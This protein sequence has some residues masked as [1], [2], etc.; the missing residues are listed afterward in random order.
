MS[1]S[2]VQELDFLLHA[3]L[4]GISITFLY[5]SF[6]VLR[7]VFKHG[8]TLIALEDIVFWMICSY[9]ILDM[10]IR[11]NSGALRWFAIGGA[12]LGMIIFKGT[13][14]RFYVKYGSWILQKMI[15]II[16]KLLYLILR[17][18]CFICKKTYLLIRKIWRI[19]KKYGQIIRN[20]LT[21]QMKVV[22][23]MLCKQHSKGE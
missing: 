4:L 22:K 9:L 13:V 10:L 12:F 6:R 8:N 19:C 20:R 3:G 21:K 11:E 16:I 7:R 17:P 18:I 14:S 1:Q 23:I 2:I 15:D 5:D